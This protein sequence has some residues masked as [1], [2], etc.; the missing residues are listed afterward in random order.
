VATIVELDIATRLEG[1]TDQVL[2]GLRTAGNY[3]KVYSRPLWKS[4][5]TTFRSI[6]KDIER[7]KILIEAEAK[8]AG[9]W[10]TVDHRK[11][12]MRYYQVLTEA[13]Q[14][15]RLDALQSGDNYS[16]LL[17]DVHGKFLEW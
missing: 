12:S 7:N 2:E 5:E 1:D 8:M 4:Y 11:E 15:T 10:I 13:D 3:L 17:Q 16:K 14:T 6:I 9:L